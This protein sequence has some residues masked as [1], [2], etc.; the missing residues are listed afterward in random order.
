MT[1]VLTFD[2]FWKMSSNTNIISSRKR[3]FE[4]YKELLEACE[5]IE[6]GEIY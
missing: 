1:H 3:K 6:N 4:K 2:A 5:H